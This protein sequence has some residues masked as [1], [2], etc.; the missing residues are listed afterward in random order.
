MADR[1]DS[2]WGA[3]CLAVQT[4]SDGWVTTWDYTPD[5][6]RPIA[7]TSRKA[8]AAASGE[9]AWQ[10]RTGLWGTR[11]P[12]LDEAVPAMEPPVDCP[13]RFPGQHADPETGLH[14]NVHRYYDPEAA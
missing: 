12:A 10:L 14:Y 1:T 5:S 6:P 7:R 2:V 13:L 9:L 11:V 3:L 8:T 4:T